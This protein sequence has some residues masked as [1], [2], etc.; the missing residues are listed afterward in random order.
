MGQW[1]G[2]VPVSWVQCHFCHFLL[3]GPRQTIETL[4]SQS[5]SA[6]NGSCNTLPLKVNIASFLRSRPEGRSGCVLVSVRHS[7]SVCEGICEGEH[8]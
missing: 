1:S 7:T 8:A 3:G 4:W 5:P 2:L 6:Q